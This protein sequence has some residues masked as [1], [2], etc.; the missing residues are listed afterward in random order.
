MFL[1]ILGVIEALAAAGVGAY[2]LI[3][4]PPQDSLIA[5]GFLGLSFFLF[6]ASIIWGKKSP[7]SPA[8][9]LIDTDPDESKVVLPG[10]APLALSPTSDAEN[11][12][13]PRLVA[14]ITRDVDKTRWH[15][16]VLELQSRLDRLKPLVLEM[17][18]KDASSVDGG[19]EGQRRNIRRFFELDVLRQGYDAWSREE[20]PEFSFGSYPKSLTPDDIQS[21][22]DDVDQEQA[23]LMM[24]AQYWI[25][26]P[27]VPDE[28]GQSA[29]GEQIRYQHLTELR[30]RL[31]EVQLLQ[32]G[33]R[34]LRE[35]DQE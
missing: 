5:V 25:Q 22:L 19:R 33:Y 7:E 35:E 11:G 15:Y 18:E 8:E 34:T 4:E 20:I 29:V 17:A 27:E 10:L 3:M 9:T 16:K 26:E 28:R 2:I 12:F 23:F 31:E 30:D 24:E 14:D 21:R 13:L 1:L 32:L 6:L